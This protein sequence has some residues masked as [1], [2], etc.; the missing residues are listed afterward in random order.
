[1]TQVTMN[2]NGKP[3][4]GTVEGRTLLVSFLREQLGM[5]GT[6]VGCDTSQCGA[7][8]VHV[9]GN[10]VFSTTR[11]NKVSVALARLYELKVHRADS[12]MIL[13]H[14]AGERA[15]AF[16]DITIQ[17]AQEADIQG[18]VHEDFDVHHLSELG[19]GK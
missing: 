13:F 17:A 8:V 2:V 5:T 7:C 4:S 9:D 18:G 1:M 15:V 6:H 14:H 10:A 11:H 3:M 12:V 16:Y 19:V